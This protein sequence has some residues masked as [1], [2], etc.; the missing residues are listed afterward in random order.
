MQTDHIIS[1]LSVTVA[2][3]EVATTPKEWVSSFGGNAAAGG[4]AVE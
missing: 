2:N 4:R 1:A 3:M